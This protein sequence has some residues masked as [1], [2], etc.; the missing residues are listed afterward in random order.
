MDFPSIWG[1]FIGSLHS[2]VMETIFTNAKGFDKNNLQQTIF[3]NLYN[4]SLSYWALSHPEALG[5]QLKF[6][7]INLLRPASSILLS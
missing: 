3:L 5:A 7:S 4:C 1:I 6:R 2:L